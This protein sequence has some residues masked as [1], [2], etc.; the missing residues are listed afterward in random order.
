[1][2]LVGASVMPGLYT[3]VNIVGLAL[4]GLATLL[5]IVSGT[6]CI[7]KNR[8]VLKDTKD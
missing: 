7:I 8:E 2:L 3:L 6:E 5:T 4:L 1:V